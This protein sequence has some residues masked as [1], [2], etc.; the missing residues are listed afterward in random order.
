[1]VVQ[2]ANPAGAFVRPTAE[3]RRRLRDATTGQRGDHYDAICTCIRWLDRAA[4]TAA[5]AFTLG[6]APRTDV[7]TRSAR[8]QNWDVAARKT[9]AVGGARVTLRAQLR[10]PE[11]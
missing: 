3:H 10:T 11:R 4:W 2:P 8:R 5:P 6:N 7:R 1:V 9:Q